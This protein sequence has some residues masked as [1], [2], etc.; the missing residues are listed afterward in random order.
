MIASS[1]KT[2]I[3]NS[4]PSSHYAKPLNRMRSTSQNNKV[5]MF[6]TILVPQP[7]HLHRLQSRWQLPARNKHLYH[8][9]FLYGIDIKCCSSVVGATK[10][11]RAKMM[12]TAWLNCVVASRAVAGEQGHRKITC[13]S[14][15]V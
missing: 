3:V 10:R 13:V 4:K 12:L 1:F 5:A 2:G 15:I 11:N 8:Y 14:N 7:S 9:K 6:L